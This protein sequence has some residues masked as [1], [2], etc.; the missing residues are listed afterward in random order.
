MSHLSAITVIIPGRSWVGPK[1][2]GV[3]KSYANYQAI[4]KKKR[5]IDKSDV[6]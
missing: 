6:N 5:K 1:P 2:N 4:E 3:P